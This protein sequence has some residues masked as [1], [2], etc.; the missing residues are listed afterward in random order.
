MNQAQPTVIEAQN[1]WTGKLN[2]YPFAEAQA[3]LLSG[4]WKV[5]SGY[6]HLITPT[7]TIHFVHDGF[8]ITVRE[9]WVN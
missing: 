9:G 8:G 2:L 1:F 4:E 7:Q 5:V 3:Q 6:P